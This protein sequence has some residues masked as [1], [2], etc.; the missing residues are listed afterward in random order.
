MEFETA[1]HIKPAAVSLTGCQVRC[2]LVDYGNSAQIRAML[3]ALISRLVFSISAALEPIGQF[4]V[5]QNTIDVG[6]LVDRPLTQVKRGYPARRRRISLG[7]TA[8][9]FGPRASDKYQSIR[10]SFLWRSF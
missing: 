8:S 1:R 10:K 6:T 3:Q 9:I 4:R 2:G 7:G 5:G